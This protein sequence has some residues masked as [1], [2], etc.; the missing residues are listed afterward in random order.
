MK[1]EKKQQKKQ[2]L[3]RKTEI[4]ALLNYRF[5]LRKSSDEKNFFLFFRSFPFFPLL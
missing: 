5:F 1:N 4:L 2:K 3:F